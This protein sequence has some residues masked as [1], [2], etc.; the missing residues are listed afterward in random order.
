MEDSRPI[1][2]KACLNGARRPGD[3]PALPVTPEALAREARAAV[4]AGAAAIH[5]HPRN[6]DGRQT[7]SAGACGAAVAAV[8]TACPGVPVGLT[9]GAWIEPDPLRRNTYVRAWKVLPDFVS[10]NF[11]EEGVNDFCGQ[12]GRQGIGVEAGIWTVGDARALV[13]SRLADR[14]LRLLLEPRETNGAD[15][16]R[17]VALIERVLDENGVQTPR[18]LHGRAEAAWPV[19]EAAVRKGY[20]IRIGLEDTL[21]LPDGTQAADNAALVAAAVAIVRGLGREVARAG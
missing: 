5:I 14:C 3:H 13:A 6:E 9:T 18:L 2:I 12:L 4:D 15:A 7:L 19:L 8:R 21:L 17:T 1:L 11:S 16:L 20:D 10:V